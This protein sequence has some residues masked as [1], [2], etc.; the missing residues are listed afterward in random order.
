[1]V[2]QLG[3]A[4]KPFNLIRGILLCR[5]TTP[6][7]RGIRPARFSP[8]AVPAR[9]IRSTESRHYQLYEHGRGCGRE[10]RARRSERAERRL[11][12]NVVLQEL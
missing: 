6:N 7:K 1:M 9:K 2:K 10:V 3:V 4:I 8:P 11:R 12:A 5:H